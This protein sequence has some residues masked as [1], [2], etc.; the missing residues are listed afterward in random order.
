MYDN[1]ARLSLPIP[2][3]LVRITSFLHHFGRHTSS[4]F[5]TTGTYQIQEDQNVRLHSQPSLT[6]EFIIHRLAFAFLRV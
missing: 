5:T 6:L 3:H 2:W 4:H 1:S